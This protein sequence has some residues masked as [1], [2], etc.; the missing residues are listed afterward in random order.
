MSKIMPE[1]VS[2]KDMQ[3]SYKVV[4]EK[5]MVLRE[6]IV[7]LKNNKPQVAIVSIDYLEDLQNKVI[8]YEEMDKILKG[9]VLGGKLNSLKDLLDDLI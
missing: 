2:S 9:L 3:T 1:T 7:V 4:F 5:A 6:P 8:T